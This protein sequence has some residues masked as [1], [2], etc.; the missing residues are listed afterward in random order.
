MTVR[1]TVSHHIWIWFLFSVMRQT[2]GRVHLLIVDWVNLAVFLN[3]WSSTCI[4]LIGCGTWN[5]TEAVWEEPSCVLNVIRRQACSSDWARGLCCTH[6]NQFAQPGGCT[7][8]LACQRHL[9]KLTN[10][11]SHGVKDRKNDILFPKK[12]PKKS[13]SVLVGIWSWF[14]SRL[15]FLQAPCCV[16]CGPSVSTE[17]REQM[18][19]DHTYRRKKQTAT[20]LKEL[21]DKLK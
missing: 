18:Y 15:Y 6:S 5:L 7:L 10:T 19:N 4:H 12:T 2:F 8:S 20:Q 11:W 9:Q 1:Y 16:S 17:W 14:T 3:R 21:S 13:L